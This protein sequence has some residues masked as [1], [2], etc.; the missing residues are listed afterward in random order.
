MTSFK[1]RDRDAVTVV[2]AGNISD[3]KAVENNV[4]WAGPMPGMVIS[5]PGENTPGF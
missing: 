5:M 3:V 4:V 1:L 2:A